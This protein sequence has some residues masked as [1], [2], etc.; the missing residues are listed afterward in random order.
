MNRGYIYILLLIVLL[1]YFFKL[2]YPIWKTSYKEDKEEQEKDYYCNTT[3]DYLDVYNP[4]EKSRY[5]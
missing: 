3:Y 4:G 2:Y 1:I 5:D